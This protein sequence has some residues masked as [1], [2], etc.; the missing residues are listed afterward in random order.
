MSYADEVD[1]S[2]ASTLHPHLTL[3]E[4]EARSK[5]ART[6]I[7]MAIVILFED[8]PMKD[9]A[10]CYTWF[11]AC[12]SDRMVCAIMSNI[13]HHASM[14]NNVLETEPKGFSCASGKIAA[15]LYVED[16]SSSSGGR[17]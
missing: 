8:G 5:L 2:A 3:A 14:P 17:V 16:V 9:Q 7:G 12:V 1:E 10:C 13:Q 4:V 11:C 15:R 6:P